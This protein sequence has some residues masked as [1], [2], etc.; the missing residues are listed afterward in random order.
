M[1]IIVERSI[2]MII[3]ILGILEA[4]GA[5]LP[6]L[7]DHP[8]ERIKYMLA[9][10][11]AK[12][13]LSEVSKVSE[14]SGGT[15]IVKLNELSEEFP[16]HPTHLTHHTHPTHLCYVI[17][18][19]GSTGNP[20][21]VLIEHKSII[22][23]LLAMQE[24]Y[25]FS[26]SD[27]SL[28]KTSYVFDVSV[29][30]LFG[31]FLGEGKL[32]ILEKDGEKD[33]GKI[34]ETIERSGVTHINF[35]PSMFNVFVEWLDNDNSGKLAGLKYLFL[36]GEAIYP[37]Y[38]NKFRQLGLACQ[39]ENIYGPT[40]ASIY[41]SWYSL[42]DWNGTGCIPIGKPLFNVKLYIFARHEHLQPVGVPGELYISGVG[43]ARG[44]MNNPELTAEKF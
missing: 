16:T 7:P 21:G 17:Y 13:L 39:L 25:P 10:S 24:K 8:M 30:E 38:V 3:G 1:G 36:A 31:W 32:A 9:D 4:G 20:K 5:Y 18:T 34:L 41:S 19:S 43:L 37:E 28:L 2:E 15:E 44:Y 11:H 14:L 33:P 6:I 26:E 40:E 42:S 29:A 27:V 12:I 35:V 23:T 22:N